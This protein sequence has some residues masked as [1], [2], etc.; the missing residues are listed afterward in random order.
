[1]APLLAVHDLTFHYP[2][3][4]PALRGVSFDIDSGERVAL[5]GPTG[6]GKSTLLQHLNGLLTPSTGSVAVDGLSVGGETVREVRRKVGLVFQ[7]PNDQLFLPTL[8][9]DVAFGPLNDGVD[10]HEATRRARTILEGLGL[11]GVDGRPA[12]HLSG[13]ERRLAALATVLVSRPQL[14]VLDEPTGDLDA[15]SRA[16]LV[17]LLTARPETLLAAT[18]DL[19][20]AGALCER[21][22]VLH[23]GAVVADGPLAD[24]LADRELLERYGLAAPLEHSR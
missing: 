2:D 10:P 5:L 17:H 16:R 24:L 8:L 18:H 14:L 7:D 1:M 11:V 22:V 13:G 6:S 9:E 15:V 20:V 21:G 19:H 23:R 4:T 12:H 3:G